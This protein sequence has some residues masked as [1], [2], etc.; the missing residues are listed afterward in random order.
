MSRFVFL[1]CFFSLSAFADFTG[2]FSGKGNAEFSSG[3]HY[4]CQDIFLSIRTDKTSFKL[5]NGGYRC[6]DLLHANFD[7]FTL[8]L[9]DGILW[10]GDVKRGTLSKNELHYEIFDPED[11]STYHLNLT[12]SPIGIM[13]YDESW[14][15]AGITLLTVTGQLGL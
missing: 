3:N 13:S 4:D 14:S 1:L 10:E 2:N 8:S 12:L 5:L 6:G 11:N 15:V 7:P 9:K